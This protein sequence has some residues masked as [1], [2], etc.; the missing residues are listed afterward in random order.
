MAA[1]STGRSKSSGPTSLARMLQ[2]VGILNR[3]DSPG[4][5][6]APIQSNALDVTRITGFASTVTTI[7]A[8]AVGVFAVTQTSE[9]ALRVASFACTAAVI[10]A[11]L[12]AAAIVTSADIRARGGAA[13]VQAGSSAQATSTNGTTAAETYGAALK[14]LFIDVHMLL[15]RRAP[16]SDED[17]VNLGEVTRAYGVFAKQLGDLEVPA[18]HQVEHLAFIDELSGFVDESK[19][20]EGMEE[21]PERRSACIALNARVSEVEHRYLRLAEAADQPAADPEPSPGAGPAVGA[22]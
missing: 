4:V 15:G 9:L 14:E 11:A 18:A 12:F 5:R 1:V 19:R 16:A 17:A 21:G 7:G 6:D 2:S 10:V 8:A 22:D 20:I 13:A 3:P